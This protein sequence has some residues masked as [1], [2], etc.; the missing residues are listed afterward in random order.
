[1]TQQR[2]L[3]RSKAPRNI[4]IGSVLQGIDMLDASR[5]KQNEVDFIRKISESEDQYACME[6][7]AL[8]HGG[9]EE[10]AER[11][12]VAET[13]MYRLWGVPRFREKLAVLQFWHSYHDDWSYTKVCTAPLSF[14]VHCS[15]TLHG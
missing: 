3:K 1:M 2:A 13:F 10:I 11:L 14:C 9:L 4:R 7:A 8:P 12:A 15:C 6:E 5:F